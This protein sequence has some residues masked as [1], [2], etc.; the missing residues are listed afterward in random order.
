MMFGQKFLK[1]G[2]RKNDRELLAFNKEINEILRS[3][4]QS[5]RL[6]QSKKEWKK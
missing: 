5:Y 1:L 2:L 3:Y 6:K 4:I